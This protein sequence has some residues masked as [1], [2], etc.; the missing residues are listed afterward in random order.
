ME[1]DDCIKGRRSV[2]TYKEQAVPREIIESILEAGVWAPTGM[3]TQPWRFIVIEDKGII[4]LISDQTKQVLRK[5][6]PA[7]AEKFA[8]GATSEEA[9]QAL[10]NKLLGYAQRFAT[11]EDIICYNAPVLIL[12]CTEVSPFASSKEDSV[13]AA[14]NMFLKAHALGLG[15]CYMGFTDMMNRIQPEI[16]K[17]AAGVPEGYEVQVPLILGYPKSV[18]G[19][20]KRNKPNILKWT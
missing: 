17:N 19:A 15:T 9:K 7:L 4:K 12:I 2:R 11:E 6:L 5:A 14:Q 13:L 8:A 3:N 1:L 16:L 20:G 18:L 10:K